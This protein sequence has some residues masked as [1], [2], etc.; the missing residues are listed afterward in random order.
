MG[1]FR[2]QNDNY[3]EKKRIVDSGVVND[4]TSTRQSVITRVV[5]RLLLKHANSVWRKVSSTISVRLYNVFFFLLK[6]D[7]S[8]MKFCFKIF[9]KQYKTDIYFL[10]VLVLKRKNPVV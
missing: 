8:L 4:V 1:F 10:I 7:L 9:P 6:N 5:I 2:L 3:F